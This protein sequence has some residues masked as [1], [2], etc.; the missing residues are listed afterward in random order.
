MY[1]QKGSERTASIDGAL[2]AKDPNQKM[3][4]KFGSSRGEKMVKKV[5]R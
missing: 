4:S 2:Q 3:G 1:Q 5:R